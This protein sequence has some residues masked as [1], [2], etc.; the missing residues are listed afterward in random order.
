MEKEGRKHKYRKE[1]RRS[2]GKEGRKATAIEKEN[3][4]R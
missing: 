2:R 4:D 3:M 1:K